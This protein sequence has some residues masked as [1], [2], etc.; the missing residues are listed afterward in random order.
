[1][2]TFTLKLAGSPES[3]PFFIV[4]ATKRPKNYAILLTMSLS[5]FDDLLRKS[6]QNARPFTRVAVSIVVGKETLTQARVAHDDLV[7]S[8][9]IEQRPF[10]KKEARVFVT[11]LWEEDDEDALATRLVADIE[12]HLSAVQMWTSLE[13]RVMLAYFFGNCPEENAETCAARVRDIAE[14]FDATMDRELT[15][16]EI[17]HAHAIVKEIF[18]TSDK[19]SVDKTSVDKTS[20]DK[21]LTV[22]MMDAFLPPWWER[23]T[24]SS[25]FV[26]LGRYINMDPNSKLVQLQSKHC[27]SMECVKTLLSNG[28]GY[29]EKLAMEKRKFA[30]RTGK[31]SSDRCKTASTKAFAEKAKES[32]ALVTDVAS[33]GEGNRPKSEKTIAHHVQIEALACRFCP[34]PCQAK[35]GWIIDAFLARDT[36]KV[37]FHG[38]VAMLEEEIRTV[39]ASVFTDD[40]TWVEDFRLRV[41]DYGLEVRVSTRRVVVLAS[42]R[43]IAVAFVLPKES[44]KSADM[45]STKHFMCVAP[46]ISIEHTSYLLARCVGQMLKLASSWDGDGGREERLVRARI[47]YRNL[48]LFCS[49]LRTKGF[50]SLNIGG[51]KRTRIYFSD[52]DREFC[53]GDKRGVRPNDV[54]DVPYDSRMVTGALL[55]DLRKPDAKEAFAHGPSWE[56]Q[57]ESFAHV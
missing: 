36:A 13:T 27:R 6:T 22:K 39:N 41:C 3:K 20:V 30:T 4:K 18:E 15:K 49:R 53:M 43:I 9:G 33:K 38:D 35:V 26:R 1:M 16:K 17:M 46:V 44:L 7:M 23:G 25:F 42:D 47:F 10:D 14:L 5:Y 2:T 19:S 56:A 37:V 31:I 40:P 50:P 24:G 51:E 28:S 21:C 52:Y 55:C 12:K 34:C 54:C 29:I 11:A 48:R 45:K 32:S 8:T 57:M